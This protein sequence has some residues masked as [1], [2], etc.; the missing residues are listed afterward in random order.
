MA[1][2]NSSYI[3]DLI[4][5]SE[6]PDDGKAEIP[7][8]FAGSNVLITG[9]SGFFGMLL[10][11]KLLRCCPDIGKLYMFI[12]PKK[13]K[14][15]EQRVKEQFEDPLY[16]RLRKE[17]PNFTDK[18]VL[19]EADCF[20]LNLGLLPENR[21]RLL[22]TNIII[23]SA[24]TV[25]FNE[26]TRKAVNINIRGTKQLLL[27]AKEMPNLKAFVY[28]S[29]AFSHCVQNVIEEKFYSPPIEPDKI[30]TLVDMLD[31]KQLE[32]L[33]PTLI[34]QWPNIYA[35]TKAIAE[36]TVRQYG[37]GIPIC[38]VRP[39]IVISTATEPVPGWINN[40]YG[41][42]GIVFGTAIGLLRT[43]HCN[44]D[45]TAEIVPGDYVISHIV[46]VCWDTAKKKDTLLSIENTNPKIPETEKV[47]IYNYV[48]SCQNPITW[49]DYMNMCTNK[50]PASEHCMWYYMLILNKHLFLHNISVIFL[51]MIPGYIVDAILFLSGRKPQLV[52]VYKKIHKFEHVISYFST[53]EWQ[54]RN[55][56]VLK[57]WNRMNQ[58]DRQMF[59]FNL[60]ELNWNSCILNLIIG[61]RVFILKDP[62][63]SLEKGKAKYR[64]L[65]IAH[66]TL[67]TILALLSL[68]CGIRLVL[69]IMSFF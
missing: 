35:L 10:I 21:K 15:S 55:D 61:V 4:S 8:F 54:F 16:E 58:S 14:S 62:L 31:D 27:L 25:R 12:R 17:R 26:P 63:D 64:K 52:K 20:E 56:A 67:M 6:S 51:H 44:P 34:G 69:Y 46:A 37:I 68:W 3:D 24:A 23:H 22:D 33:T 13:E 49:K 41:A 11:E 32:I 60:D 40:F 39:S 57:L 5:T 38:I 28:I 42:V 18:V 1:L 53:Q 59:N 47:P 45:Y 65:K 36:E 48:S 66:Y 2:T 9:G 7:Q 19:I 29:T 50:I 43:L 30:L